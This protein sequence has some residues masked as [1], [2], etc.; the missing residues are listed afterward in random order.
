MHEYHVTGHGTVVGGTTV[1][2][3]LVYGPMSM[4]HSE[5]DTG[6]LLVGLLNMTITGRDVYGNLVTGEE[7]AFAVN[8]I[9]V[10]LTAAAEPSVAVSGNDN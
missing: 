9:E 3:T 6:L 2:Y 5:V 7:R 4:R 8:E 10:R 1:N